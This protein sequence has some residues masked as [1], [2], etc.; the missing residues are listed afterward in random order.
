M[1]KSFLK[2]ANLIVSFLFAAVFIL[3]SFESF[4]SVKTVRLTRI[5]KASVWLNYPN[6]INGQQL[7]S[8]CGDVVTD[9]NV[10]PGGDIHD[11]DEVCVGYTYH[12]SVPFTC[13]SV[14]WGVYNATIVHSYSAYH[15]LVQFTSNILVDG[16]ANV[17]VTA[18]DPST[19]DV[20]FGELAVYP[21]LYCDDPEQ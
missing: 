10:I 5:L 2:K 3:S 9:A 4:A 8:F 19:S 11:Q 21:G 6:S 12:L 16:Y 17:W 18:V 14:S 15:K 20:Y 1:K 13:T 7:V